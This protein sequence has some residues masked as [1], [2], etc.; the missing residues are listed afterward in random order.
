V[1]IFEPEG[2][3]PKEMLP[4]LQLLHGVLPHEVVCTENLTPFLKLLPCKGKAGISGLLDGHKLFDASFQVMAIDVRPVCTGDES[5]CIIEI[6]QTVDMVLD[7]DRSKRPRG[8]FVLS[9]K[10]LLLMRPRQSYSA[11]IA[12]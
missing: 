10:F 5:S 1:K 11:P 3:H 8:K 9:F 2:I 7:L 12:D 6:E 4:N